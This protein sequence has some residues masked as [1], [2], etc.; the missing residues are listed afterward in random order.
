MKNKVNDAAN[1]EDFNRLI[2]R[3]N[4]FRDA[5][6]R[7]VDVAVYYSIRNKD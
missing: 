1:Y 6:N 2:G 4:D 7:A 3:G 5:V